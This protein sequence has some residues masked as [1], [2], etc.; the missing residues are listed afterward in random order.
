M[1]VFEIHLQT[2]TDVC[3]CDW[4]KWNHCAVGLYTIC[5]SHLL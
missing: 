4:K 1:L 3:H 2:F 5:N